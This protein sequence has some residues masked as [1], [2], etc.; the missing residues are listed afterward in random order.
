MFVKTECRHQMD[1]G[2]PDTDDG[3]Q[4]HGKRMEIFLTWESLNGKYQQRSQYAKTIS[5]PVCQLRSKV[6]SL[7]MILTTRDL[8]L[9]WDFNYLT[10]K[11][12]R[13]VIRAVEPKC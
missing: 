4:V 9:K 13:K 6:C 5:H 11:S 8:K 1:N 7:D 2:H 10:L 12:F 3:N